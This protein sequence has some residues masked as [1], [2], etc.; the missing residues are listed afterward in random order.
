M[1]QTTVFILILWLYATNKSCKH[2]PLDILTEPDIN[3]DNP[4]EAEIDTNSYRAGFHYVHM[5][6]AVIH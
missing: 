4:V 2:A 5:Y 3:Y 6:S 1:K